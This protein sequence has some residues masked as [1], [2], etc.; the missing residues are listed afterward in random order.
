MLPI[1]ASSRISELPVGR[2]AAVPPM[3]FERCYRR[4]S[5]P[6]VF[7]DLIPTWKAWRRWSHRYFHDVWGEHTV[8]VLPTRGKLGQYNPSNGYVFPEMRMTDAV[9]RLQQGG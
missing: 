2:V 3:E 8:P 4:A 9:D 1:G 6:V 5:K 7:N